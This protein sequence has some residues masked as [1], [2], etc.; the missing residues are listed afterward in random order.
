VLGAEAN[1]FWTNSDG[2]ASCP[3]PAFTCHTRY[4]WIAT[5]GFRGGFVAGRSLLYL[6]VGKAWS[7]GHHEVTTGGNLYTSIDKIRTG[8]MA[9]GGWE[10]SFAY[11]WSVRAEYQYLDF[12]TEQ[13]VFKNDPVTQTIRLDYTTHM[14]TL[15]LNYRIQYGP[16]SLPPVVAKN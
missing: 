2:Q 1:G 13:L 4:N 12:G 14:L 15:G 11:N 7:E 6:K 10:F 8:W 9:G 16:L 3:N 5:A